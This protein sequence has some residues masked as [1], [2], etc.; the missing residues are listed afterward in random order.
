[1]EKTFWIIFRIRINVGI[2][3]KTGEA[4]GRIR[5][6]T[7]VGGLMSASRSKNRMMPE[8]VCFDEFFIIK[9]SGTKVPLL[10]IKLKLVG[11]ANAP[12][13]VLAEEL[14]RLRQRL[15]NVF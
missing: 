13:A 10:Y 5:V 11:E 9:K 2:Q 15:V 8:S 1:M 4:R 6:F 14:A 7:S 3:A 12:S